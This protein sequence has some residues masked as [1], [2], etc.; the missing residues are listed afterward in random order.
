MTLQVLSDIGLR[1]Y[2]DYQIID[3]YV[4]WLIYWCQALAVKSAPDVLKIFAAIAVSDFNITF[5]RF[6]KIQFFDEK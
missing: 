3:K 2:N 6:I 4:Y 1:N 5:V